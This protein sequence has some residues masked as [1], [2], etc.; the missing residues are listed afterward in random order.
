MA[1]ITK[2]FQLNALA[3]QYASAIYSDISATNTSASFMVNA[4]GQAIQVN[5][6]G[7]ISGVRDLVDS[8]ALEALKD[9][10]PQWEAVAIQ[11]LSKCVRGDELTESGREIWQSMVKDMGS[12]VAG[13]S[14]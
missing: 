10:Y 2:N 13:G 12:T 3:N 7:G 6:V 5:I 4:G 14:K 1:L 11:I 8:Y 9:N